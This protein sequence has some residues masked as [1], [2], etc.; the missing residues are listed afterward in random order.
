MSQVGARTGRSRRWSTM[1]AFLA[2]SAL[3]LAV[4]TISVGAASAAHSSHRTT[5]ATR[6]HY[7]KN[8]LACEVTDTGG[9]NDRSFNASAYAAL[10]AAQKVDPSMKISYLQSTSQSDYVPNISTFIGR[11]CG[12]IVTV[13]FLMATATQNAAKAHPTQDFTIVDN[14]YT[15]AIKNVLA[16]LYETNQDAFLGGF[17]A[18][19]MS[20]TGKVGTFGGENIPTVTIYMDGW[21]AGVRYFDKVDHKHVVALG[22]TPKPG[23]PANSLAGSG[24]FTSSFTNQ[25]DGRTDALSLIQQGA[26]V[27]FPVAGSVGLGAAEAVKQ[28]HGVTMEWVDTDG[29]V[30]DPSYCPLFLTSVT[31]G[32]VPSVEHAVLLAASGKF[33]GGNYIGTLANNGV[34]ISPYHDYAK[35]IP[36]ALQNGLKQI[37]AQIIAGKISVNPNS[38]PAR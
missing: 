30:S 37:R 22:W 12:I 19:A 7:A 21:V 4:T 36:K 2:F 5:G 11:H 13:G 15:P 27:I 25:A 10:Q 9:I 16:L 6:P 14:Q 28:N 26:D 31:K 38:Y 29:C 24:L 32:I 33:K 34:S 1:R 3:A 35:T 20:K 23:R 17:L 18:A 8:F